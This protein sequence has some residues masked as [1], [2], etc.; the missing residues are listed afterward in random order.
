MRGEEADGVQVGLANSTTS[1]TWT[2]NLSGTGGNPNF[3]LSAGETFFFGLFETGTTNVFES[4]YI[5]ITS[6]A[7]ASSSSSTSAAARASSASETAT[8]S[9]LS[10]TL[11]S[12][13]STSTS[14]PSPSSQAAKGGLSTTAKTGLGVGLGVGIVALVAGLGTG[15]FMHRRKKKTSA[16][17]VPFMAE[18]SPYGPDGKQVLQGPQELPPTQ[19]EHPRIYEL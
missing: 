18:H 2:V 14:T 19:D 4:Q 8:N 3:T 10:S 5:N 16:A 12:S 6:N 9:P 15:Y 1:F 7:V 17:G 13:T 11:V